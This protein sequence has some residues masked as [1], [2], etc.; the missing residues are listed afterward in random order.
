MSPSKAAPYLA[1]AVGPILGTKKP[2]RSGLYLRV[3]PKTGQLVWS[4][5]EGRWYGY[6]D[7]K[8]GAQSKRRRNKRSKYQ[9]Q[10]WYGTAQA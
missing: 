4:V 9:T 1:N 8:T 10:D 7:S 2:V 5:Y 3:S 6:S